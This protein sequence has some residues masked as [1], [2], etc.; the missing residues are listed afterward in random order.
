M[1]RNIPLPLSVREQGQPVGE[2]NENKQLA[3]HGLESH[4]ERTRDD[5][6]GF[7]PAGFVECGRLRNDGCG[8]RPERAL[9]RCE[10]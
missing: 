3:D 8:Q 9:N 2:T 6:F 1:A 10:E 7:L 4:G 5:A